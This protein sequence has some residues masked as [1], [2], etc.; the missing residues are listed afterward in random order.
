[1]KLM[2][3]FRTYIIQHFYQKQ[4]SEE[5]SLWAL[6][7]ALC[8]LTTVGIA[9]AF[10]N[11]GGYLPCH[12][13]LIERVPY[14]S[15]GILSL[16]TSIIARF[17]RWFLLVRFFLLCICIIM[18]FSFILAI[19]HV[20]IEYNLWPAPPSCDSGSTK[21]IVDA[22]RLLKQLNHIH[23]PSCSQ[24]AGYFFFLSFAGWNALA[25]LV[26]TVLSFFVASRDLLSNHNSS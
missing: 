21:L 15:A 4:S 24:A 26:Y 10:E 8:L 18:I 22:Q 13:C 20:G 7:L 25:S 5:Q 11:I 19:Y 16:I 1:M 17:T 3:P 2:L 9:I 6:L 12:L 23:P 14:Y